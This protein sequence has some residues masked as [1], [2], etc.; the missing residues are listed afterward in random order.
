MT[1]IIPFILIGLIYS[2][3]IFFVVENL[4]IKRAKNSTSSSCEIYDIN[5]VYICLEKY[6]TLKYS[7]IYIILI[8]I[9]TIIIAIIDF[10]PHNLGLAEIVSYVLNCTLLVWL[11]ILIFK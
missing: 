7:L 4:S 5:K 2:I 3:I 8:A 10:I 9:Y 11:Y 1:N 6:Q